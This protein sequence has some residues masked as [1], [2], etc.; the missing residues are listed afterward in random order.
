MG[1]RSVLGVTVALALAV[2]S[3]ARASD[4]SA[5]RPTT[6]DA[7]A[8]A[9]GSL[10][11]IGSVEPDDA[12][13]TLFPTQAEAKQGK[14]P[15]SKRWALLIGI[16][17]Y[18]SPTGNNVGSR[19]D[20]VKLKK[21][22]VKKGWRKSHIM[23]LTD[24]KAT[25]E[26]ITKGLKWLA[27]KTNRKSVAIFHYAGHEFPFYNDPDG[28]GEG[29]DVAIHA[30]DNRYI[31]DRDVGRLL[32]RVRAKKMWIQF[33]TCRARGFD[34]PGIRKKNRVVTYSS[35]EPEYS[36]EDP[37]VGHSVFGYYSVVQALMKRK[38]DRNGDGRISVEEAFR[39]ARARV[40]QRT[41]DRQHP[42]ISDRLDG[43]FRLNVP[44]PTRSKG[45]GGGTSQTC[46]YGVCLP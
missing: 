7:R 17:E 25:A 24:G 45:G 5:L 20:A 11:D 29:R 19:Q 10:F 27:N 8:V 23:V 46:L 2:G 1:I 15:A 41:L 34:D 13:A 9:V 44:K 3:F 30:T 43:P 38:G 36:Y 22:L 4:P 26:R 32:G 37:E 40:H 28:D 31:L 33:S 16:N 6:D 12:F 39:Y 21:V 42:Q 18:R 35:R 14:H